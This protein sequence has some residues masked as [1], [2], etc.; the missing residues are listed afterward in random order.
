MALE[1][2]KA[3]N[4]VPTD[5]NVIIEIPANSASIKYEVD[6]D[7]GLLEVDRFMPTAMHYPCNY[8][9]IPNTL[10]NDGDPADA[11]VMT[12]FPVQPGCL[13]RVRALGML[14]MS[15]EAGED[16][17]ILCLPTQKVCS[18]YAHIKQLED[19]SPVLL[20]S[21]VHFFEHYKGLEPG[22][23]VNIDGWTGVQSAADEITASIERYQT[24]CAAA[25]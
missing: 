16:A 25:G 9:F 4:S 21:I 3:A 5:V 13:I 6:K 24:Q 10:A 2:I 8:G 18:E 17:K 23:W 22:K 12:P 1:L 19:V 14:K 7:T 11:L 15:D 20:D